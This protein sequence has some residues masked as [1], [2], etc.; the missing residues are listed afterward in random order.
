M[1]ALR[2]AGLIFACML[3]LMAVRVPIAISMFIAG[4]FG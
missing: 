3:V 4:C 2:L 1:S